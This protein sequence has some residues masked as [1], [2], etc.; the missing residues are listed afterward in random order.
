[1]AARRPAPGGPEDRPMAAWITGETFAQY[2]P[3]DRGD[4]I[5]LR[6]TRDWPDGTLVLTRPA[7]LEIIRAAE[8]AQCTVRGTGR[9]GTLVRVLTISGA[10]LG[11]VREALAL[12]ART[13][14]TRIAYHK[15]LSATARD[16]RVKRIYQRNLKAE[17]AKIA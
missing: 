13:P 14:V 16:K 10:A 11:P 5:I 8:R 6:H 12:A 7:A 2:V 17:L 1:M 4:A 3:E 15:A 9:D